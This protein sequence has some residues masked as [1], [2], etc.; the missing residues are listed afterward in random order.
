[1]NLSNKIDVSEKWTPE[2]NQNTQNIKMIPGHQ[3]YCSTKG[4][5]LK[6]GCGFIAME[7]LKLI[8][9][10]DLSR[11]ILMKVIDF[12]P[13]GLKLLMIIIHM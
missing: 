5:S 4:D 10:N 11:K 1:M 6:S 2:I 8:E 12:S 13:V 7:G 3:P 9:K